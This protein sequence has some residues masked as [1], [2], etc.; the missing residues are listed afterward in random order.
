MNNVDDMQNKK[1]IVLGANGLLG[2]E[3]LGNDH[4]AHYKVHGHFGRSVEDY[5]DL[6]KLDQAIAYLDR[7][8]P[9]VI[10]NLVALTNVDHC[11]QHP[12]ESYVINVKVVENIVS[13]IKQRQNNV[14]LVHISTDQVYDGQGPHCE[15]EVALTNYY[16]FSKYTGELVARTVNAAVLRTNFF[17]KSKTER[18]TSFTDWLYQTLTNKAS[19]QVFDDVYFSPLSMHTLSDMIALVVKKQLQG[20]YN[21]GARQGLS[22]ADFAFRFADALSLS[23]DNMTRSQ[24]GQVDFV[25][26]YR[27]KDMRLDVSRFEHAMDIILPDL[28]QEILNVSKEYL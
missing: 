24:I 5:G 10:I 25:K 12:N 6:S 17:G 21:L 27:P 9:D 7:M 18:R 3:L 23:T 16:A 20:T 26:T 8:Q 1:I 22:K 13:W 2:N 15:D 4:F 11:E 14:H 28:Q 19:I